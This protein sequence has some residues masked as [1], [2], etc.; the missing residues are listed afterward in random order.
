MSEPCI[1]PTKKGRKTQK[2][3]RKRGDTFSHA[4][5]MHLRALDA[6]LN[7]HH[8]LPSGK[9]DIACKRL[10]DLQRDHFPLS[11]I[12]QSIENTT[13]KWAWLCLQNCCDVKK[14]V[15]WKCS[16][17][18]NSPESSSLVIHCTWSHGEVCNICRCNSVCLGEGGKAAWNVWRICCSCCCCCCWRE[19]V[20]LGHAHQNPLPLVS[21]SPTVRRGLQ[22]SIFKAFL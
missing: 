9:R 3:R 15:N 18:Y 17:W 14:P 11:H 13:L 19:H 8:S 2:Q 10:E 6:M 20:A 1:T 16:P 22:N 7:K 12:Q 21:A 4:L 5:T